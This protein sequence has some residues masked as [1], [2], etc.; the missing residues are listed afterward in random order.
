MLIDVRYPAVIDTPHYLLVV[1]CHDSVSPESGILHPNW[2]AAEREQERWR[3][4]IQQSPAARDHEP[5]IWRYQPVFLLRCGD[6]G[7]TPGE[8]LRSFVDWWDLQDE[9]ANHPGWST[10]SEQHVFCPHHRLAKEY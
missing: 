6:C 10:T 4:K 5:E 8:G 9:V 1:W 3:V 2:A 7:D